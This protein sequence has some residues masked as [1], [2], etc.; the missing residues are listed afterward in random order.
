M[1]WS[2]ANIDGYTP[3]NVP[4]TVEMADPQDWQDVDRIDKNLHD[5]L[6]I[7]MRIAKP[8]EDDWKVEYISCSPQADDC[9]GRTFFVHADMYAMLTSKT[10]GRS[11]FHVLTWESI[12]EV[13]GDELDKD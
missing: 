4:E 7:E 8:D 11:R 10:D 2:L 6:V 5:K 12:H 1:K 9:K 3:A 13:V